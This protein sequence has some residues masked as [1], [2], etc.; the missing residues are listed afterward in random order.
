MTSTKR[1]KAARATSRGKAAL[2]ASALTLLVIAIIGV[3]ASSAYAVGWE[4]TGRAVPTHLAPGHRGTVQL[5]IYNTSAEDSS[6]PVTVTDVLP[7]GVTAESAGYESNLSVRNDFVQVWNCSGLGTSVVS[8]TSDLSTMPT[9]VAGVQQPL[10]IKVNV[11]AEASGTELNQATVAGGGGLAAPVSISDPLVLSST[12]AGFGFAGFD[13]WLSNA[14]GTSDTQ[15]GSHPYELTVSFDLNSTKT[16]EEFEW[17]A[18]SAGGHLRS[19]DVNLPPGIVGNPTVIPRCSRHQFDGEVLRSECPVATQVGV[20]YPGLALI[21]EQ[22]GTGPIPIYNLVPPAGVSAEFAFYIGGSKTYLDSVVRSGGDYGLRVHTTNIYQGASLLFNS[23][24]IWGDPADASHDAQREGTG[25]TCKENIF[26]EVGRDCSVASEPAPLLTLPTS[27]AGPQTF[28]VDASPWEFPSVVANASFVSH[29]SSGNPSGFTGC[30][31]LGFGP[32]LS[33][34]PDTGF[35]DTPAGLTVDVKVPQEG[36]ASPEGIATSNIQDTTVTLPRGVVIN[37]GQ[38][39]GLRACQ[40]AESGVG[41]EGPPSCPNASK[42]GTDEIETPL[43][44]HSLK[45]DVYVLQSDPPELK[46]LVAASGE[47]VNLKLLGVVHLNEQTGQLTTTFKETPELPFTDFKLSFSGGAQ[48]A[49]ATPTGCGTYETTSDF[50]PWSSPFVSD[51][52]P[53]SMFQITSGSGGAPCPSSPLPF[54]PS[55]VAGATTDQAGG[56]TQFSLLLQAPDDQQRISKLQFRAPPGLSGMISRVPLCQEPQ[57]ALGTCPES[58]KIGHTVIASGPG[59]YPL[60]VPQP[61]QPPAAIY[62]T[63][64]YGGAPF[65]LSIVVPV[66]VGPFVLQTQVVRAKIE[67]DPYTAQITVTTDPLPQIIDGVPTDLRSIDAVIDREGFMFN[68]TNCNPQE[69]S[70]TAYGTPPPGQGGAGASA[71]LSSHFQ[72]GSCQSLKFAPDFKVLTSGKTSRA[73]GASLD[74][75]ILYP[76]GSLGANQAS[77]QSN[78][79]SVKV[80]LPRQLPSRL[81]TLQKACTAAQ[82]EANPAGC[83]AASVVGHATVIT[84]ILPVALTGPAYFVS[85][86]GEAFPSLIVVLQGYGVTVDLV[87][88]TFISKAGIT[89]STFK[90]TPDVPF[91]SFDLTLPEGRFSALAANG[92]LCTS[93]L[94]MPTAFVA[95]NGATINQSTPIGVTGCPKK[96][97]LTRTQKL[98]VALKLCH[99]DKNHAKRTR[100]EKAARKQYGPVRTKKKA[101]KK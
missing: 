28:T 81:T 69:F 58:S 75:K 80:D 25:G 17:G 96:R 45:G 42:I 37:P 41:T 92:D 54:A 86:G 64:P 15:A 53:S 6:G 32:S 3:A 48:A 2:C 60:V 66:V 76:T 36:L 44:A 51:A 40:A 99:R 93:K 49:L 82:F 70:G 8:C 74:A 100:C 22:L 16:P 89:S 87:G 21:R 33:V 20:D 34:A 61:G 84:P 43:L 101:K 95:Q 83:P 72:V 30:D 9:I 1:L 79:A 24:T 85:H 90:S 52:F 18:Q 11:S 98:A 63:G 57:A 71:L 29:D 13:G 47:G 78:I 4:V 65:G 68:P 26:R 94:A 10:V 50:T 14:N 59:P 39:A 77:Q 62:L 31:H 27:C 67:V 5:G 12:P 91:T 23:A 55:M 97:A 35:A 73:N 38:A 56:F 7:E 88:T 46:L 19:I